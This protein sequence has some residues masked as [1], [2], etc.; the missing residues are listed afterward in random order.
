MQ[1][2]WPV[3]SDKM[4]TAWIPLQ[5]VS[6]EMGPLEFAARS[7]QHDLGRQLNIS[8]DNERKIQEV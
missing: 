2:Y 3:S 6:S 7:Q 1:Y 4:V 5:A 8:A